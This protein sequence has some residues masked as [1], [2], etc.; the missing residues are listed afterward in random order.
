MAYTKTT[1]VDGQTVIDAQKL[2]KIEDALSTQDTTLGTKANSADVYTKTEID[3]KLASAFEYKGQVDQKTNLPESAEVGDV[4]NVSATDMNYVWNGS[5]WDPLG[6]TYDLSPYMKT[7]DANNTFAPKSH[8]HTVANITDFPT[9]LVRTTGLQTVANG[10]E[11]G[12]QPTVSFADNTFTFGIPAGATGAKGDKGDPGED[13]APGAKGADGTNATITSATATV[14]NTTSSS[15]TCT[16]TL[17]GTESARTF[18]F[19][20]KGIKG[21]K[22]DTGEAGTPGTN[23]SDGAPGAAATVSVGEVVTLEAGQSAA[24]EN[25]GSSSAAVFK[26]SIPKGQKGDTGSAGADGAKGDPGEAATIDSITVTCDNTHSDSP[27]CQVTPGGTA[28][29]RTF[30]LAFT[31]LMGATGAKGDPGDA[32]ATGSNGTDGEDGAPGKSFRV[33]SETLTASSA[34]CVTASVTPT[35][36]I[37]GDTVMDATGKIYQVTAVAGATYTIGALLVD[38]KA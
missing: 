20:F 27:T 24:V 2:N 6:T 38:L 9:D 33:T 26:F 19:A 7:V 32:G 1:W 35:G 29:N 13:G 5:S 37:T 30:T 22:G 3:S 28:Q 23:G 18:Q 4:Y 34:A 12:E 15:P 21:A 31:G 11:A 8:T 17:G 36:L 10:L 14:D 16:V 25:T